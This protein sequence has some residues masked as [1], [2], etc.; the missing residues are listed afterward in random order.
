MVLISVKINLLIIAKIHY[1]HILHSTRAEFTH[2][3]IMRHPGHTTLSHGPLKVVLLGFHCIRCSHTSSVAAFSE[4]QPGLHTQCDWR[5]IFNSEPRSGSIWGSIVICTQRQRL[6]TS[7]P[8]CARHSEHNDVGPCTDSLDEPPHQ[9]SRFQVCL[10]GQKSLMHIHLLLVC[11]VWS[12]CTKRSFVI[13]PASGLIAGCRLNIEIMR[14]GCQSVA[15]NVNCPV[16]QSS[17]H[18]CCAAQYHYHISGKS[19]IAFIHLKKLGCGHLHGLPTWLLLSA[20]VCAHISPWIWYIILV[21]L[22]AVCEALVWRSIRGGLFILFLHPNKVLL[23][24]IEL[25]FYFILLICKK[26]LAIQ[27]PRKKGQP[28]N[29][30]TCG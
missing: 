15:L 3:S 16:A 20:L 2:T 12:G 17:G 13:M 23:I 19:W 9:G 24:A 10:Q 5:S 18:R 7:W 25:Y 6:S 11:S 29:H 22:H 1:L 21:A 8:L 27:R 28:Y 14:R 26:K 4:K 30:R